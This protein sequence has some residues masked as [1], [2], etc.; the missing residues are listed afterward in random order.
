MNRRDISP[1]A[2]N[3][4]GDEDWAARRLLLRRWAGDPWAFITGQDIDGRW[5]IRTKNEAAKGVADSV[6]Q[7]VPLDRPYLPRLVSELF[8]PEKIVLIHKS[9]QMMV[10]TIA[11]LSLYWTC[12]FGVGRLCMLS[13]TKEGQA[14]M[15]LNDKIRGVHRRTPQWFQDLFPVSM[16][17]ANHARFE[18]TDSAI[19][20]VTESA[21]AAEFRG[22][23][24]SIALIDEAASQDHF[25]ELM[26][27]AQPMASRIWAPTT[28]NHGNPGGELYHQLIMAP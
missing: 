23:T 12:V 26:Q 19:L 28:P 15:M 22:N 11:C 16:T 24:V 18:R 4:S 6:Y 21:A 17:P 20:A 7:P 3:I 25:P 2:S 5:M 27:S 8:G 1:F 10:S 14:I 9:R 13:K